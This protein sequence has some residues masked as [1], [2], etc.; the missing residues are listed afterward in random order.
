MDDEIIYSWCF[1]D[2][3]CFDSTPSAAITILDKDLESFSSLRSQQ[4]KGGEG[5]REGGRRERESEGLQERERGRESGRERG[6]S[7]ICLSLVVGR[8]SA[9]EP[10]VTKNTAK[11]TIEKLWNSCLC[12]N[13]YSPLNNKEERGKAIT[14]KVSRV[15][16]R[17]LRRRSSGNISHNRTIWLS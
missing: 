11:E 13:P 7:G 9:A 15:V 8:S 10:R 16:L 14:E 6:M 2:V 5:G 4:E 17:I 1:N 3:E 12:S